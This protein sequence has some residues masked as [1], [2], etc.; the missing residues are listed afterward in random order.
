MTFTTGLG[1]VLR[2]LLVAFIAVLGMV[3]PAAS[4]VPDQ[5]TT[6]TSYESSLY[7]Q[8]ASFSAGE[9]A[10]PVSTERTVTFTD[11]D[12]RASGTAAR[13]ATSSTAV[14]NDDSHLLFVR[15]QRAHGVESESPS[16]TNPEHVRATDEPLRSPDR[17]SVAAKSVRHGP[18][19]PGPLAEDV[20]NTFRS[21]SYTAV[22][23]GKPTTLY[24]VDSDNKELGAYWTRT[25]PSGPVQSIIDSALDPAWGNQATRWVQARVPAGTTF[26]EGAAAAQRGLV[27]GG[28]QVVIPRVDPSWVVGR[29]GF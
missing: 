6:S 28:N 17:A 24:R 10:P 22:T 11:V 15:S 23:S 2:A 25:R 13:P 8:P 21:G 12:W 27:G 9:R 5:P 14:T 26:Y 4:A 19:N 16:A 1:A 20:A 3:V 29:G 18:M 7:N